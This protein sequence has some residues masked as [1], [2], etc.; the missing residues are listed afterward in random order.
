MQHKTFVIHVHSVSFTFKDLREQIILY[1]E[2]QQDSVMEFSLI[3]QIRFVYLSKFI[4]LDY[5]MMGK[6][7]WLKW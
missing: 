5:C 2:E 6:R 4:G 3:H 1:Q 7:A